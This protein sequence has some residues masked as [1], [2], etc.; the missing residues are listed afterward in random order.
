MSY[1]YVGLKVL[2][3]FLVGSSF[4][5]EVR[6]CTGHIQ[7]PPSVTKLV[8]FSPSLCCVTELSGVWKILDRFQSS[9]L[10]ILLNKQ[11]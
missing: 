6:D 11:E 2:T 9:N 10:Y 3:S 7:F 4:P 8:S 1:M 5:A